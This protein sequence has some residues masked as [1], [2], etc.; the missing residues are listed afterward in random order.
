MKK[1]KWW[2]T[3]NVFLL[4]FLFSF[5]SHEITTSWID[6]GVSLRITAAHKSVV[7]SKL[8]LLLLLLWVSEKCVNEKEESSNCFGLLCDPAVVVTGLCWLSFFLFYFV[9]DRDD[10][11]S[12]RVCSIAIDTFWLF[13][14]SCWRRRARAGWRPQGAKAKSLVCV[15]V[16]EQGMKWPVS[17]TA[18]QRTGNESSVQP[19]KQKPRQ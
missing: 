11:T 16:M 18:P 13:P 4:L 3:R 1:K 17:S 2:T 12:T 8:W 6:G 19:Q 14:T 7:F 5:K 15:C 10:T 9:C